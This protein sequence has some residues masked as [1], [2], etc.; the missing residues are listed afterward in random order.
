M[1]SRGLGQRA[2]VSCRQA[3]EEFG[4]I[5]TREPPFEWLGGAPA[6]GG[7]KRGGPQPR[8]PLHEPPDG[9]VATMRAAVVEDPEDTPRRA[10]RLRGPGR[11]G[12]PGERA[13]C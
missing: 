8:G 4:E 6:G 5:G 1:Y 3:S 2:W 12:P 11:W 7:G 10:V 13:T 9:R